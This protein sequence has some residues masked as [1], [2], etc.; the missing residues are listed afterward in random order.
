MSHTL[1]LIIISACFLTA[2][3]TKAVSHSAPVP[4]PLIHVEMKDRGQGKFHRTQKSLDEKRERDLAKTLDQ[5]QV[6][7]EFKSELA[8]LKKEFDSLDEK[9][10]ANAAKVVGQALE[11]CASQLVLDPPPLSLNQQ[12][13]L[14]GNKDLDGGIPNYDCVVYDSRYAGFTAYQP[15]SG[16]DYYHQRDY[17]G[18]GGFFTHLHKNPF[19]R[20]N[21]YMDGSY[22]FP[23][24]WEEAMTKGR[25]AYSEQRSDRSTRKY[26]VVTRAALLFQQES[27]PIDTLY[28]LESSGHMF[29]GEPAKKLIVY[30]KEAGDILKSYL[31][32]EGNPEK[33]EEIMYSQPKRILYIKKNR[34]V[35]TLEGDDLSILS[36]SLI[37]VLYGEL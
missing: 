30:S 26:E 25:F 12:R 28:I 2:C 22:Q 19:V 1:I 34:V 31:F 20:F 18:I 15:S 32:V 37:K 7:D 5:P 16:R 33:A 23:A 10:V 6:P 17:V 29:L 14:A 4:Y 13:W 27:T 9:F 21:D 8:E 36:Q 35:K 11:V 3:G 24:E